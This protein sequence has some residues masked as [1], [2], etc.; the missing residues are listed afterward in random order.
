MTRET[1]ILI[2]DRVLLAGHR[3]ALFSGETDAVDRVI[4]GLPLDEME[5]INVVIFEAVENGITR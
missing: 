1:P 3:F 2:K 4:D 5:L